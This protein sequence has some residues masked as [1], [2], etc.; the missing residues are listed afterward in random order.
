[1]GSTLCVLILYFVIPRV[2]SKY[3]PRKNISGNGSGAGG[4]TRKERILTLAKQPFISS[5][6][7]HLRLLRK[8]LIWFFLVCLQASS[9]F[10]CFLSFDKPLTH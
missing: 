5:R 3:E 7:T 6:V 10:F 2:P 8:S 9:M 1:M 4:R